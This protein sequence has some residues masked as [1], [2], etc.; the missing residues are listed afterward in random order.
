MHS[1]RCNFNIFNLEINLNLNILRP[2]ETTADYGVKPQSVEI[3]QR[4]RAVRRQVA[5]EETELRRLRELEHETTQL[6]DKNH[7]REKDL[8]VQGAVL[9]EAQLELRNA[10]IR[11][12]SL[13]RHVSGF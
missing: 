5:D 1:F 12:Q 11:T 10:S 4:V 6:R 2:S 8:A 13:N 7:G 9:K 3:V